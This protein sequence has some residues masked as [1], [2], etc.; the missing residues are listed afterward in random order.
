MVI[1]VNDNW[2]R[3]ESLLRVFAPRHGGLRLMFLALRFDV[4]VSFLHGFKLL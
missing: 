2:P 3:E 4:H 1:Y